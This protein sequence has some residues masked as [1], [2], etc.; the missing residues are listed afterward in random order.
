MTHYAVNLSDKS[1]SSLFENLAL[2]GGVIATSFSSLPL[3]HSD[4][5]KD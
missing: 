3:P 4:K 1:S 2:L 5:Y